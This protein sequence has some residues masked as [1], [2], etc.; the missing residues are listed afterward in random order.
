VS[1]PRNEPAGRLARVVL[2]C[3]AALLLPLALPL[4]RGRVFLYNDL[5]W[6]H[7]PMRHLYQQAL[8]AGDSLLWTPSIFNGLY[9][10]GEGQTGVLHPLHLLVYRLLPLRMAFNVEL[11]T[12]YVAAFGGM[13]WFLRR[14]RFA[15]VPATFG[16]MLFAFSGFLLLHHHHLNMVAVVAHLPWLLAAADML[17]VEEARGARRRAFAA[18]A[19]ILA[20][21]FLLGFPQAVWWDALTLGAFAAWRAAD[22]RRWRALL[23]L[24]TAIGVG[25]L[26]GGIQIV[27]SADAVAHSDRAALPLDFATT[28]SLHPLN[29][30][31]L[32]SPRALAGGIYS[33]ADAP[34]FHEFGIYSGA[35]LPLGLVWVW[36]RRDAN[37]TRR[38]LITWTTVFAA[39]MGVLMLGR[40]GGVARLLGYLPVLGAMRAPARYVVLLQFA[41]AILATVTVEDLV[42]I[43]ER[44]ADPPAGW[45]P[46]LWIPAL[47]G[48]ATTVAVNAHVSPYARREAATVAEAAPGVA[49]IALISVLVVLAARRVPWALTA[50]IVTTAADLGLY[51]IA[52]VYREP[53]MT[54][55]RFLV[56]V[57]AAPASTADSYAA[58]PEDGVVAKNALVLKGYRLSTGYAGFF[59]AVRH[60]IGG[61]TALAL[62]GTRWTFT[63]NGARSAYADG[64]ARVRVLD[65]DGRL[66]GSA[67]AQLHADRAGWL[68]AEVRAA[69]PRILAFTERFHDG[70]T[71]TADGRPLPVVPVEGDF[72]GCRVDAGVRR[73]ELRFR[74]RS[75][76]DG[77]IVSGLGALALAA[78]LWRWPRA[79]QPLRDGRGG[80]GAI[81]QHTRDDQG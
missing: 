36:L 9:L 29:L 30:L 1:F 5:I 23:P 11:L 51:G 41:L 16:A 65:A 58:A 34:W 56:V 26:L 49:L 18:V 40:Y 77:A 6:F 46:A 20:S 74:P 14:L 68:D 45:L 57:K 31:Q 64:V 47:L 25:V 63:P 52:F 75:V 80:P 27:P 54:I 4:L 71:A 73:V 76:R 21:A 19:L 62:S 15:A 55:P 67:F 35:I 17:L 69:G 48:V 33:E 66:D 22:T 78:V 32:W 70:W 79:A 60:P 3:S 7:L 81:E 8:W 50:L 24:A 37:P 39:V 28:F 38:T 61:R 44:R 2:A 43:R 42:A 12:S 72:L 53:A 13:W 10:L 59:P